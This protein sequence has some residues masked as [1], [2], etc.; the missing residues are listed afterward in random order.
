MKSLST[1]PKVSEGLVGAIDVTKPYESM[2][3]GAMDV[4]KPYEFIWF[5]AMDVAKPHTQTERGE[6]A[7]LAGWPAG[8]P[9]C[10]PAG[11]P[12]GGQKLGGEASAPVASCATKA[13]SPIQG[14][15]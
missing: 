8:R 9:A 12:A 14:K 15:P 6:S 7:R 3:F 10:R 5:G 11:R 13:G 4:T 2:G 1:H